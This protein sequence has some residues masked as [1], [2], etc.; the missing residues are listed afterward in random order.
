MKLTVTRVL[1]M[2]VMFL[3]FLE[4]GDAL[5]CCYKCWR[6]KVNCRVF[7]MRWCRCLDEM[8]IL[9]DSASAPDGVE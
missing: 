9:A 7:H 4:N 1:L 5:R 6:R 8:W 2:T 3:A